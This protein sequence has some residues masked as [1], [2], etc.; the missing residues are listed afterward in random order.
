MSRNQDLPLLDPSVDE[1]LHLSEFKVWFDRY[2]HWQV[3]NTNTLQGK[4]DVTEFVSSV[5]EK[6]IAESKTDNGRMSRSYSSISFQP[7]I[8]S[9]RPATIY[10]NL[11]GSSRQTYRGAQR[12][13]DKDRTDGEE[14]ASCRAR[15][16]KEDGRA[17]PRVRSMWGTI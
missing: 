10:K 2:L 13:T 3:P 7:F 17:E 6:L 5:S 16:F 8:H 4:F 1:H 11:R 9:L 12:C 14:R 15:I